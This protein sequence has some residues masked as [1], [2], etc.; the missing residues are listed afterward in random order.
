MVER[1]QRQTLKG[2]TIVDLDGT[3]IAGNSM[4]IF[5][6][7]LPGLLMKRHAY[8]AAI[9]ALLWVGLR[10]VRCVNHKSMKWHLTKKA[11]IHLQDSDWE[12]LAELISED[13]NPHVR[14]FVES[15]RQLGCETYIATAALE[16]YTLPLCKLLGY[17]GAIA[18]SF[19]DCQ[20]DYEE[21]KGYAKRD[22]VEQLLAQKNLRLS[23]FITDHTDDLPTAAAYPG[24]SIIVNPTQKTADR[25]H[26]VGVTRYMN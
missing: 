22:A 19:S 16:E 18:T 14:D 7:R 13:I 9:S 15:N 4:H 23:S 1:L 10:S 5:M 20:D 17:D 12:N 6:K 25:F 2:A 8:G 3:L 21:M 24:L 26:E 11:L